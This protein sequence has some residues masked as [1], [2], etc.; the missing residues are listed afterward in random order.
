MDRAIKGRNISSHI[1]ADFRPFMDYL[2]G[3]PGRT[4]PDR[5]GLGSVPVSSPSKGGAFH[6]EKFGASIEVI[7]G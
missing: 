5:C 6:S 4:N 3:E 2:L 7:G 1:A